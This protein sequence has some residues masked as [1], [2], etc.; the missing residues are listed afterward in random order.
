MQNQLDSAHQNEYTIE[1]CIEKNHWRFHFKGRIDS[2][3]KV[4]DLNL[5]KIIEIKSCSG[6]LP[7]S[8]TEIMT[9]YPE[10]LL[11]VAVYHELLKLLHSDFKIVIE[12]HFIHTK[13]QE[14]RLI[15]IENLNEFSII[16][17]HWTRVT[18]F[19]E[20]RFQRLSKL[21]EF[22]PVPP[23]VNWRPEQEQVLASLRNAIHR[24]PYTCFEAPT[25]FGKTAVMLHLANEL[26]HERR[27]DRVLILTGKKSGQNEWMRTLKTMRNRGNPF[28]YLQLKSR[29]DLSSERESYPDNLEWLWQQSGIQPE[30]L[31]E[32]GTLED[33]TLEQ[34][35]ASSQIPQYELM[36]TALPFTEFWVADYNYLFSEDSHSLFESVSDYNPNH[37]LVIIDEAHN[38]ESRSELSLSTEFNISEIQSLSAIIQ[39]ES[40]FYPN[41]I[42]AIENLCLFL[43]NLSS[44]G[45]IS[46]DQES[47]LEDTLSWIVDSKDLPLALQQLQ[48]NDA[49]T[50]GRVIRFRN[51]ICQTT[52]HTLT[53]YHKG[54]VL[55]IQT[56]EAGKIIGAQLKNFYGTVFL[57]ATISPMTHFLH[58][59]NLEEKDCNFIYSTSPWQETAY[60]VA[61]DMRVDTRYKS[62]PDSQKTTAETIVA[63]Q[64]L[65]NDRI[66]VYFPSYAYAE[67][68]KKII[69]NWNPWVH[70]CIQPRENDLETQQNFIEEQLNR[71]PSDILFLIM[72]SSYS[73]GIDFLNQFSQTAIIVSPGLPEM[74]DFVN[75][76]VEMSGFQ[77][78]C[79]IPAIRKVNQAIGRLVR[80]PG[81]KAQILLHCY[82]FAEP[83]FYDS[84]NP[85]FQPIKRI[86]NNEGFKNWLTSS[87]S[88]LE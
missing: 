85:L 10:Y 44:Y 45:V 13:T 53:S 83:V 54:N 28:R 51:I 18:H 48:R 75:A 9:Q 70:L 66:I 36:R 24:L 74:N 55:K 27:I 11:Q 6:E 43:E 49:E 59:I 76:K 34:V 30:A 52:S 19:L 60:N 37:T 41:L 39:Q 8:P 56:M 50:L 68:V 17:E 3:C 79:Q 23:F 77:N 38:L 14:S 2:L 64:E 7:Q 73:E 71:N 21:Y 16:D 46:P 84:L 69:L 1:G 78:T 4:D 81:D 63:F 61:I 67:Q 58:T 20:T 40:I 82:R 35:A 15:H 87:S 80:N 29:E 57:S 72:G 62:R 33:V 86:E 88:N 22:N 47:E 65:K 26:L 42:Q 31:L 25:G 32:N 12:F 5:I